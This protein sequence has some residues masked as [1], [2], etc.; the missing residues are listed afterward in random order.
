MA[1][2]TEKK[3]QQLYREGDYTYCL[4]CIRWAVALGSFKQNMLNTLAQITLTSKSFA[5]REEGTSILEFIA[6]VKDQKKNNNN[7]NA[8]I[9][10]VISF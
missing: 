1:A 7:K 6:S 4:K 10:I 5:I 3:I 8:S 2:P 9:Y